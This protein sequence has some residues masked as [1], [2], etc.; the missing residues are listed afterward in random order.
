MHRAFAHPRLVMMDGLLTPPLM[1][2][3]ICHVTSSQP[4]QEPK[5]D[6]PLVSFSLTLIL[7]QL[8]S[9]VLVI[10]V[11]IKLLNF[12]LNLYFAVVG[13]TTDIKAPVLFVFA[14]GQGWVCPLPQ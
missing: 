7:L 2:N 5:G 1:S 13:K 12:V 4:P 11:L 10:F 14:D 3:T 9:F 6:H 8:W